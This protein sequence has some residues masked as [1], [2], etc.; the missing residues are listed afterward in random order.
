M[1]EMLEAQAV[2]ALPSFFKIFSRIDCEAG[3]K[4][5]SPKVRDILSG[6]S[7]YISFSENYV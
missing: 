7:S 2:G 3:V 1:Q 5:V 6:L 4:T